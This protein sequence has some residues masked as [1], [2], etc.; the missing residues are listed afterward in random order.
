VNSEQENSGLVVSGL[1]NSELE[2][3]NSRGTPYIIPAIQ[4]PEASGTATAK[5]DK[6]VIDHSHTQDG[7][8]MAQYRENFDRNVRLIV[9]GSDGV[10]YI[11]VLTP[12]GVI[13]AFPLSAGDGAYVVGI[14]EEVED[15][16]YALVITTTVEASLNDEFAPFIRPNQFI[17]YNAESETVKKAFELARGESNE[18]GVISAIYNFVVDNFT[19][20]K[21][22]AST[23]KSGYLPD[24]DK[25]LERRQGI[26]FDYAAVTAAMLRSLGIPTKLV[27]GY[28]ANAFHAWINVYSEEEGWIN[29]AI[30]FDG[31]S[32]KLMD[33]TFASSS[34]K[35]G[36]IMNFIGNGNN[37]KEKYFY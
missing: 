7:Y 27:T 23:V 31:E 15:R 20:D 6:A 26:C 21:N 36:K 10:E 32:W 35:S 4:L 14:F 2:N 9:N 22:L 30:F 33:P 3:S 13:E 1:R 28:A 12:G 16:R 34:N 11:Y 5:N 8:I 25:V 18:A 37:Y 19:Y 17:N 24:V 29:N